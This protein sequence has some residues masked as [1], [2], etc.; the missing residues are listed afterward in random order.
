M[1]ILAID[2]TPDNLTALRAVLSDRLPES[3]VLTTKSGS[4]GLEL[5]LSEDPDVILLDIVMPEMDGY[6]VCRRLKDSERMKAIPVLFLTAQRADRDSRVKALEMGAEGFLAKPFDEVELVAQIL[7]MAK[8]KTANQLQTMEKARLEELVAERTRELRL[9]LSRRKVADAERERFMAAIEQA[10]ETIMIL[11]LD[12]IIQYVNPSFEQLTQYTRDDVLGQPFDILK[13]GEQDRALYDSIWKTVSSGATWSGTIVNRRK[14]GVLYTEEATISPVLNAMGK[15]V[16][17]VAVKRDI[18]EHLRLSEQLH[19]AQKMESVG[20]L[21]GGVAHDFNNM[22]GVILG[23]AEM[24]MEQIDRSHVLF[25]D[26]MEIRKA[27]E[28]SAVLTRQLLAFARRQT[29]SPKLLDVNET[30]DGMLKMLR[31]L[32][33]E[34]IDLAW[35]PGR[36]IWTIKIDPSQ[37]DQ[38]LANLCVNARDAITG[39]GKITIQTENTCFDKAGSSEHP[40]LMPGEFV[41]ITVSDDGCGMDK[42]TLEHIFEPFFTTKEVGK[43]TGLGLATVYGIVKQNQGFIEVFS[44]PG[45]GTRF[46][47]YLPRTEEQTKEKSP[48]RLKRD[49]RGKETVLLVEDEEPMLALGRTILQRHGYEVLATRSPAEALE[50]AKHHPGPIH[51]LITDV[52][53]PEMNGKD[54]RDRLVEVK[55][56][57]KNIFMS[58]YTADVIAHHGILDA[59]VNFLQ[60]PF[61][62][63]N[64]VERVREVLDA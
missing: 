17:Y 25:G 51:L 34:D 11:G 44:E 26:L 64:L 39:V 63:H 6:E 21:A 42:K 35:L 27:A 54:L 47:I 53:M 29:S 40:E 10:G 52:V 1:K 60:K 14:D 55:P 28:R 4:R 15:I 59:N 49:L 61:S 18:T 22:L 12:G 50:M 5:A 36:N 13:S 9:E 48:A 16:N 32:I 3:T 37:I 2:D 57:F 56:G 33:G 30:L 58:G 24:A 8:I 43:G 19:Q 62:I 31:R 38:I 41:A 7:A 23:H 20:R 45:R 46:K